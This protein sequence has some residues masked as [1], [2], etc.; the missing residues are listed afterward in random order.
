MNAR[1]FM[2]I[3]E[4]KRKTFQMHTHGH[5]IRHTFVFG[6]TFASTL[7]DRVNKFF[8]LFLLDFGRY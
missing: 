1:L 2:N 5:F 4:I 3:R 6:V 8:E 7:R